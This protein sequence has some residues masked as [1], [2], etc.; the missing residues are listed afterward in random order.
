MR[1]R[2]VVGGPKSMDSNMKEYIFSNIE[3]W[4]ILRAQLEVPR[5]RASDTILQRHSTVLFLAMQDFRRRAE[6]PTPLQLRVVGCC[7]MIRD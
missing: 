3:H 7:C 5:L 4:L 1:V 2:I 6:S